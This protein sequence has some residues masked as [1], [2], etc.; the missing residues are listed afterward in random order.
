MQFIVSCE[1]A[2]GPIQVVSGPMGRQRVHFELPP[3]DRLQAETDRF[4]L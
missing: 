2:T 4:L 1:D 3:A